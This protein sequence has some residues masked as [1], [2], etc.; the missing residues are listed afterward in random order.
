MECLS[1]E[2]K[3]AS[4]CVR[5]FTEDEVESL[6]YKAFLHVRHRTLVCPCIGS[7]PCQDQCFSLFQFSAPMSPVLSRCC[8]SSGLPGVGYEKRRQHM[9]S[10]EQRVLMAGR[11]ST[12]T[13]ERVSNSCRTESLKNPEG[14]LQ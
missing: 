5:S 9:S 11:R 8:R 1:V 13:P 7:N 6:S 14:C 12:Q 10:R 4:V 2:Q 3:L